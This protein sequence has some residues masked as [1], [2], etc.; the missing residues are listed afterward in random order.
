MANVKPL[1][2][3]AL[4]MISLGPTTRPGFIW[5]V[6][7]LLLTYNTFTLKLIQSNQIMTRTE[8][9]T[10]HWN[11]RKY[12]RCGQSTKKITY[13]CTKYRSGCKVR[14]IFPAGGKGYLKAEGLKA[15]IQ[16]T[17]IPKDDDKALN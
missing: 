2:F 12:I 11:G 3:P 9:T 17:Y 15:T 5:L 6:I 10:M 4:D 16:D 13:R 8:R 14:L 1:D 7:N